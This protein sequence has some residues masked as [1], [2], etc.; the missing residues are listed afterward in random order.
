[1]IAAL[2]C[3]LQAAALAPDSLHVRT[4]DRAIAIGMVETGAGPA[5]PA[6]RLVA[7]LGGAVRSLANG[8]YAVTLA[9]A[10][11]DVTPH[12]P[13]ARV[14]DDVLPLTTP[15]F[16]EGGRLYL[17]LQMVAELVPRYGV[18][19]AYDPAR[20]EL[21]TGDSREQGADG[22][23]GAPSSVGGGTRPASA[24]AAATVARPPAAKTRARRRR[25]V[26]DA[27]HGG[28][29]HGMSGPI[30]GRPK[31]REKDVTLAVARRVADALRARGVEVAMTRTT[32]TLIALADRGRIANDRGADLFLS[33]HVNAANMR[34]KD[35]AAARGFE[36]Y[37]LAEAKTEEESRV[38]QMENEAVRFETQFEAPKGDPL[39]F[40]KMDMAQNEHLR[41]SYDLA[42]TIQQGLGRAHPG[43]NRGVKQANFAVLRTSFM[44]AVL[45]EIGFG[46]N[47]AE[48]A[49]ISSPSRQR[50]LAA[51]IAA[52]T[53]EY[54]AH[55][56]RRVAGGGK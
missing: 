11:F 47:A 55:Y 56:E 25:V 23:P 1:M 10:E 50:D 38:E 29:D 22:E 36:T 3:L 15:P 13:F 6:D 51:A 7:A 4:G 28:P 30:G 21:R 16:V 35:P 43:P 34:W 39:S 49:Y 32:D 54:L 48:A 12:V 9:G 2:W 44:P 20:G 27:G 26:V 31:I 53:M 45:I 8:H 37:F 46:T 19:V 52:G 14:R 24:P 40:I 17:P 5:V 41:E 33:I 42:G 18:G